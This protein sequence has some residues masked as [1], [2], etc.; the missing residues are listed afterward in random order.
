MNPE[1]KDPTQIMM[2]LN[3]ELGTITARVEGLEKSLNTR[4]EGLE[5]RVEEKL[6]DQAE[7]LKEL[8]SESKLTNEKLDNLLKLV[9]NGKTTWKT[10]SVISSVVAGLFAFLVWVAQNVGPLFR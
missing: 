2:A 10:I 7:E 4:V 9:E 3:R 6:K 1:N 5:K 8:K